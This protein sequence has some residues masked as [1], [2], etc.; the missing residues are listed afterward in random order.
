MHIRPPFPWAQLSELHSRLRVP[1]D[2]ILP[3]KIRSTNQADALDANENLEADSLMRPF[4]PPLPG[5]HEHLWATDP[6][7]EPFKQHSSVFDE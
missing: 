2:A 5:L 1:C 7:K 4:I 3:H 6:K